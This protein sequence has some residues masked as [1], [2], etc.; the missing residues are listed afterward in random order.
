[1]I[2]AEDMMTR[3]LFATAVSLS[4]VLGCASGIKTVKSRSF[5]PASVKRV[6]VSALRGPDVA[7]APAE[8]VGR[9]VPGARERAGADAALGESMADSFVPDLMEMGFTVVERS[10]LE[11]VLREQSLQLTGA[12]DPGT[13]KEVGRIAGVDALLVGDFSSHKETKV[14]RRFAARRRRFMRRP[15]II[16]GG[17]QVTEDTVFDSLS[18]RLVG[19]ATGEVLLSSSRREP[20]DAS[21]LDSVLGRMAKEMKEAVK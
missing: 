21:E 2:T 18:L 6:A 9:L 10:Q 19:V 12:L 14:T 3:A 11:R 4:L 1:M 17:V 5:D 20:F 7:R 8:Q 15:V 13:L 16:R